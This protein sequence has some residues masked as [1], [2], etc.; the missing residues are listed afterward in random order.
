MQSVLPR[1][2]VG[3][4]EELKELSAFA[5]APLGQGSGF[6]WWQADAWAGK[7]ALLSWFVGRCLPAG[8]DVVSYFIAE[9]LGTHYRDVFLRDVTDQLAAIVGKKLTSSRPRRPELLYDLYGAAAKAS[10]ERRRTLLLVVD[11]LDENA[12]VEGLEQDT[13]AGPSRYSIAALLPKQLPPGMRVIVSGRPNPPVPSDVPADHPLR[14]PANVRRLSASPAARVIRDMA[15]RDLHVLLDDPGVGCHLVGLLAVARGALCSRDIEELVPVRRYDIY[16][17]LRSI[18]GRNMAP[19]DADRFFPDGDREPSLQTY[20]LAHEELRKAAADALGGAELARYEARLHAWADGYR[21]MGWPAKTP[22][23]LLT[24]YTRLARHSAGAERLAALVLDPLRQLRLVDRSG[25]DVALADLD[26]IVTPK[27]GDT[28]RDLAVLAGAAVSKDL[29]LGHTQTLPSSVLRAIA[30]LGNARRARALALASAHPSAKAAAL[31]YMARVLADIDHE[32]AQETAREAAAWAHTA[33]SQALPFS[34]D[35]DEAEAIAA[36]AATAL[37]ATQQEEAG[38]QLIR[39]TRGLSTG[40][41]EAWVEAAALLLPHHPVLASQ[42]FDEMEDEAEDLAYDSDSPADPSVSIQIWALLAAA[43]P[44]RAQR[45]YDRIFSYARTVWAASP[46][47]QNIGVLATAAS[48]LTIEQQEEAIALAE[49]ARK[50]VELAFISVGA[51]SVVDDSHLDFSF[52]VALARLV[53]AL[54]DTGF[55]REH[56]WLLLDMVAEQCGAGFSGHDVTA[57]ARATMARAEGGDDDGGSGSGDAQQALAE[58]LGN[59]AFQLAELGRHHEAKALLDKALVLLPHAGAVTRPALPWL[60]SFAGALVR[61]GQ[62][63]DAETLATELNRRDDQA[64][65]F[66]AI[67][68]AYADSGGDA[69]AHKYAHEAARA[70][71]AVLN[72]EADTAGVW[73]FAAQALACAGEGDAAMELIAQAEPSDRAR[74][75]MWRRVAQRARIAIAAEI[76]AHDPTV[77]VRLVDE[78]RERLLAG[79]SRPCGLERLLADLAELLPAAV[80]S[81]EPCKERLHFA[82]Q[83]ALEYMAEPPQAWK[84]ETVLVHALLRLG[85]GNDATL[86]LNWLRRDIQTHHP[87]ASTAT[88]LAVVHAML[89]DTDEAWRIAD[90]LTAPESRA[91][92]FAAVAGYLVRVP[93]RVP[94]F[95]DPADHD[96]FIHTLR[97]FALA[98]SPPAPGD[99]ETA[100]KCVQQAL[101]T[102]GWHYTLPV[103][104]DIAPDAVKQVWDILVAHLRTESTA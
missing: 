85:T 51:V 71:R 11:G 58:K 8:V 6:V 19:D 78:E 52:Q 77:A 63:A 26:L 92:A 13:E 65:A 16:K 23:Y 15:M 21:D 87:V 57:P 17:K 98:V 96:P 41:Y 49:L 50:Y 83:G 84:A 81:G 39:S 35:D 56:T 14:D 7:S 73:A 80:A 102:T 101:A 20:V 88:G 66:A 27:S 42:L 30:R 103:L 89:R 43:C 47:L 60:P 64:R 3:R 72:T 29:L 22:D 37:I 75:A 82:L 48:A 76:A 40:R 53:Q 95:K 67:S 97:S 10:T 44:D 33:Q 28:Q 45:I 91:A 32:Q 31:T 86:Q 55:P 24:G 104:T 18:A 68:L 69:E 12:V 4:D 93:S 9:R 79:A 46:T 62:P 70:A 59:E 25:V 61:I 2:F 90:A 5:T 94:P 74:K 38:L 99:T 34:G 1:D 100:T 54:A 36:W